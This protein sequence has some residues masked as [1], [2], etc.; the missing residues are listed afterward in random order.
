MRDGGR[1]DPASVPKDERCRLANCPEWRKNNPKCRLCTG[2]VVWNDRN[3]VRHG[4]AR[5][6][7]SCHMD[8]LG[9]PVCWACCPGPNTDF[10][11][12]GQSMVTLGGMPDADRYLGVEG[13]DE[14][15]DVNDGVERIV[16]AVDASVEGGTDEPSPAANRDEWGAVARLAASR[17]LG[18]GAPEWERFRKVFS[19][20]RSAEAAA[21]AGL[22]RS[23]LVNPTSV[24]RKMAERLAGVDG[25]KWQ[26]MRLAAL[27]RTQSEIAGLLGGISKQA[28]SGHK[29]RIVKRT[30]WA[31]GLFVNSGAGLK[32]ASASARS[33][34]YDITHRPICQDKKE[35]K[36]QNHKKGE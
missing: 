33:G 4:C 13:L 23:S 7:S 3:G 14:V 17:F 20:G 28:V 19:A 29:K 35:E 5:S 18:M 21:V 16:A 31:A 15:A 2:P 6:C 24:V 12:D 36:P 27:R 8:G 25:C 30:A 32:T 9:L 34:G 1:I 10:A 22:P 26:I 11:T